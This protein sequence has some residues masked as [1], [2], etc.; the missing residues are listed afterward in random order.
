[1]K[2]LIKS[3]PITAAAR[4][5]I[6]VIPVF[7]LCSIGVLVGIALFIMM[8]TDWSF[9]MPYYHL[10]SA[11]QLAAFEA[12]RGKSGLMESDGLETFGETI[13]ITTHSTNLI[14][15]GGAVAP[16]GNSS[17]DNDYQLYYRYMENGDGGALAALACPAGQTPP[18]DGYVDVYKFDR[19]LT[20]SFLRKAQSDGLDGINVYFY[21]IEPHTQPIWLKYVIYLAFVAAALVWIL[22]LPG[23]S[24]VQ[25]HAAIGRRISQFGDFH[26][27][28]PRI[29]ADWQNPVYSSFTQFVGR[30][31]LMLNDRSGPFHSVRWYFYPLSRLSRVK[32]TPDPADPDRCFRL[33]LTMDDGRGFVVYLYTDAASAKQVEGILCTFGSAAGN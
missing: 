16:V 26:E 14:S 27:L 4:T 22:V 23:F 30:Q 3:D 1:M 18:E 31:F 9:V 7:A 12:G 15:F 5:Q 25:K 11:T 17:Y 10:D 33:A 2:K 6:G 24:W 32:L 8:L 28:K 13:T 19:D 21:K 20:D 29:L